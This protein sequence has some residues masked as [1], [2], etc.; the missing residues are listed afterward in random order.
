MY[1]TI[2]IAYD[3][4]LSA[5]Q[6]FQAALDLVTSLGADLEVVSVIELPQPPPD[7][8]TRAILDSGRENVEK[9]FR[10]LR[11]D[12]GSR[13][14]ELPTDLLVGHAADQI[15]HHAAQIK[16]DLIVLGHRGGSRVKEWLLGSVSKRVLSYAPCSV[17]I[18]G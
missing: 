14:I 6:A 11:A 5:G 4:S 1:K 10:K 12:A 16:A 2:L 17:L 18:V 7:V 15:I 8:E 9:D 13:R 3:G